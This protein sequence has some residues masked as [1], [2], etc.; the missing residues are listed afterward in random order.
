[1]AVSVSLA[2]LSHLA[3]GAYLAVNRDI[4][5]L[6]F[7]T[8]SPPFPWSGTGYRPSVLFSPVSS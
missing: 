2:F 4:L 5:S 8:G 7:V 3:V 1:M 6:L